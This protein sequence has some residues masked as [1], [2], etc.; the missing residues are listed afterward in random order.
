[1]LVSPSSPKGFSLAFF[2]SHSL[3]CE[4]DLTHSCDS[5]SQVFPDGSR[6]SNTSPHFSLESSVC[7][8]AS[9][10]CTWVFC[11]YIRLARHVPHRLLFLSPHRYERCPG[12]SLKSKPLNESQSSM[13]SSS[14]HPAV[15]PVLTISRICLHGLRKR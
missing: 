12:P 11:R 9:Y 6:S 1:M 15:N 3:H 4:C 10:T 13:L 7:P 14:V 5:L 8:P 2:L